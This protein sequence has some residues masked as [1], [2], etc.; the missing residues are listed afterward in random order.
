MLLDEAEFAVLVFENGHRVN[1]PCWQY[2][3]FDLDE[4]NND[5][6][7]AEF[8]FE[9]DTFIICKKFSYSCKSSVVQQTE[10]W[11]HEAIC[12]LLKRFSYPRILISL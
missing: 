11:C 10:I 1:R 5:K 12:T 7:K 8:Q 9:K 3:K 2:A 6:C 4:I